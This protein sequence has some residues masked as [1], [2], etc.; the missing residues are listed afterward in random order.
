M[1][2]KSLLGDMIIGRV[3]PHIYAFS[4]NTFPNFLKVGDTYR[5]VA[6]RLEEWKKYFPDLKKEFEQVAKV[7]ENSYFRDFSVHEFLEREKH[8]QRLQLADTPEGVHYSKEFFK[9]AT[10]SEVEEAI[11]DI[12]EDYTTRTNK[13]RFYDAETLKVETFIYPRVDS[14]EP[15]P[16]QADTIQKFK[17]AVEKGRTNLLMYAV[18]RFGKSFTSMCCA[19]EC[20]AKLVVI[21]SAKADVQNEWKKTVESHVKFSQYAFYVASDLRSNPHIIADRLS[22]GERAVVF[23]TL[24]DLSTENIKEKHQEIFGQHIDLLLIDESHFGA[25]A[26]KYGR[27][28]LDPIDLKART[29][30]YD[31]V[32][33]L[34]TAK[35]QIDKTLKAKIKL[36]LSGTPYRILMGSEFEADDII[37]FYQF[38][39]IVQ[40][41]ENW[42]EKYLLDDNYKEWDNPYYGFPQMIRFAFNPNASARKKM[43]EMS[44]NGV[45]YAF[46]ALLKPKSIKKESGGQHKEFEHKKEILDLLEVIDGSKVDNEVFGFL[47]YEGIK[48]G[49]MCRHIVMVLPYC[50][51]CDAM[52]SLIKN[53]AK[54]FKNLNKYEI[55]NI[56]GVDNPNQFK[57]TDAVKRK[58]S[59]C[60]RVNKKTITLTVNRMLTGTTVK[61][62]DT[63]IYLKDTAS[64]QEYDQSIFRL[65]NQY[66]K[67][68]VAENGDIIKYNMKP[69]TLLVDFAPNR[70]F[71]MQEQKAQIYNVNVDDAGNSKLA[72]RIKDEL[73]I[74]PIIYVNHNKLETITPSDILQAVSEYSKT[75]GIAEETIDIPVDLNLLSF[76]EIKNVIEKENELG[77][78]LGLSIKAS[79]GDG[80]DMDFPEDDSL[81]NTNNDKSKENLN[82]Q[83]L[84]NLK[85][86][87]K[88]FRTYYARILFYAFLTEDNMISLH[89]VIDS[90][91][92]SENARIIK[93][94]GLNKQVL[95]LMQENMDKWALRKLDYKIHNMNKLSRDAS[96][97]VV[98]R[99]NIA[100]SKFGKLGEA[101]VLTPNEIC[102][103]IIDLLTQ[104]QIDEM[105]AHGEKILDIA[106]KAGEFAVAIYLKMTNL[107]YSHES[108]SNFVYSI[109]T[110]SITYEFTHKVYRLLGLNVENI[111]Q[112]FTSYDL[113]KYKNNYQQLD[114]E[115]I[116]DFL[117][118]DKMFNKIDLNQT[119]VKGENKVKF[120][121]IVGNPPYQ[122]KLQNTSDKQL[123][124]LF[125]DLSY[126]LSKRVAMITPSKFLHNA[127]KTPKKWNQ[128]M[129]NDV[130]L[131]II[132]EYDNAKEIFNATN[133]SSGVVITFR[134][135]DEIF[136][137]IGFYTIDSTIESIK[138]KV[139]GDDFVSI[140]NIIYLQNK[141]DLNKVYKDFPELKEI[142]KSE[143]RIV[144]SAF[145]KLGSLFCLAPPSSDYVEIVGLINKKRESRYIN[146]KYLLPS[147][148]L[149]KNKV[150]VSAADGASGNLNKSNPVRILGKTCVLGKK[151][152]F[153]QTFISIGA[154]SRKQDAC[155]L[156]KYLKTKFARFMLGVLKA[157][158]GLKQ[159][160]W[161]DVPLQD[162]SKKSDINW[163]KPISDIDQQLYNK[164][165]LTNDEI[166][167]IEY[168]I[169]PMKCEKN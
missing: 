112:Y 163:S 18:M 106:C 19:L 66:V 32:V 135:E 138:N 3:E 61:E 46:S 122:E 23:L 57:D 105:L 149:N 92:V 147:A 31:D 131:K 168:K 26:Q 148:N 154:F 150:I 87:E 96:I 60:E 68:Y 90:A 27:V 95:E 13:Y 140:K 64:P 142:N 108:I 157:T 100:V 137:P 165:N 82:I 35:E 141:L 101:E 69:Q 11:K 81:T 85:T 76:E 103:E 116:K 25:R 40:E 51:S 74:S 123:Y 159:D 133:M 126:S 59:E 80:T 71:S 21:V 16:N 53:N 93:N 107:G 98:D 120:G 58:I 44:K 1:I 162:F 79:L 83:K 86:F 20:D 10:K 84:E 129:L 117:S 29:H 115:K 47:D 70:M 45:T 43:E 73:R 143:K 30:K 7:D 146:K 37:A 121:A 113:L 130:H 127:G 110:S 8:R 39:D 48:N 97:N 17:S 158:N 91:N 167:F 78:K 41:Q 155:N 72:E 160:I 132:K 6:I 118:Q 56:S 109:P 38:A 50:A 164:Y 4:T 52:E 166:S 156:E 62:W 151:V 139:I 119:I 153:S 114:F 111:A 134:D 28:L 144:S 99:C 169:K 34:S 124:N 104:E 22:S 54:S 88:Q 12:K 55:I 145:I 49:K 42:N 94:L 65:Q 75:R 67:K 102:K 77:S 136:K 5:P 24:Q 14:Y 2:D 128:K 9:G 125:M 15:R 152:G 89:D 33:D 36:H 161:S 63:M